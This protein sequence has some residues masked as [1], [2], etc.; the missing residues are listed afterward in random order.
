MPP[1]LTLR[2]LSVDQEQTSKEIYHAAA[3][4]NTIRSSYTCI[5]RRDSKTVVC[6]FTVLMGGSPWPSAS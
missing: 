1:L 3:D 4:I 5:G 2:A 6:A